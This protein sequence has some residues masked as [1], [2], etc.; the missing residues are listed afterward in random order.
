MIN[1]WLVK[2]LLILSCVSFAED[3]LTN[4]AHFQ[5][6]PKWLNMTRVNKVAEPIE[7][8]MEWNIRRVE[9]IFY[10]DQ[11]SFIQAHSL[12]PAATAVT[13]R[14]RN[15]VILGPK[16]NESN[17]NEIFGHELVHVISDQKYKE[18]IPAWLEEGM[19]NYIAK[20]KSINYKA[21]AK[22]SFRDVNELSHPMSG[23]AA[24]IHI[25]YQASQALTEMIASK[26]DFRNLLRLSVGRRMQDYL[27]NI[28]RISDLNAD[29]KKW[30]KIKSG[31]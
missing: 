14:G 30:I 17:F 25:R 29:F 12:G 23:N 8:L 21:L 3:L 18:A 31:N 10:K 24:M 15:R 7:H 16:V 4:C 1:L 19:A 11:S 6:K 2:L 22:W 13:F 27:V 28:C 20:Q 26:C 5:N 9:V